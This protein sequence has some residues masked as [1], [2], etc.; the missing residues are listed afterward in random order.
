M[1]FVFKFHLIWRPIAHESSLG[2]KGQ[3]LG[4]VR[5]SRNPQPDFVR[6]YW[7]LSNVTWTLFSFPFEFPETSSRTLSS[8]TGH[9][10][11]RVFN[12]TLAHNFS[13][14]LLTGYPIDLILFSL[15]SYLRGDHFYAASWCV[16]HLLLGFCIWGLNLGYRL[17]LAKEF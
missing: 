10:P 14:I 12:P 3:I 2:R 5:V 9:C 8:L 16:N 6:P 17:V 13:H 11:A 4:E 1:T 7:T 15:C